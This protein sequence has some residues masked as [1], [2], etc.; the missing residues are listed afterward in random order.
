MSHG[1]TICQKC[2]LGNSFNSCLVHSADCYRWEVFR[3]AYDDKPTTKKGKHRGFAMESDANGPNVALEFLN[4]QGREALTYLTYISDHYD[5]LPDFVVFS[6]GH[7]YS[8]H[9]PEHLVDILSSLN[10]SAVAEEGYVSLR[11]QRNHGCEEGSMFHWDGKHPWDKRRGPAALPK[12][13][14]QFLQP[15]GFGIMPPIIA[16]PCCAQFAVTSAAIRA[17]PHQLWSGFRELLDKEKV[18]GPDSPYTKG[19]VFELI[20]HILFGKPAI[21]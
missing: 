16:R 3:Y 8:W 18:S 4:H 21:Q 15:N 20:W 1:S 14:R 10:L 11:C 2:Q 5:N 7:K 13:W 12:F 9:Q 19:L 17:Q 6:H